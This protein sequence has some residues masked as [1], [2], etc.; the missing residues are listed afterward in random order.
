MPKAAIELGVVDRVVPLD[1]MA[2]AVVE[3]VA[4]RG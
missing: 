1:R 3:A 2:A 4:K